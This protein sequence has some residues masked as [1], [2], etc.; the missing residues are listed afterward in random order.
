MPLSD[1]NT[2]LIPYA[3]V[4]ADGMIRRTGLSEVSMVP[5]QAVEVDET[6]IAD[7]IEPIEGVI[8]ASAEGVDD[9]THRWDFSD[10]EWAILPPRPSEPHY[11]DAGTEAWVEYPEKPNA[12]CE[13]N[14]TKWVDS[15]TEGDV[16]DALWNA[17][18]STYAEIYAVMMRAAELGY[19]GEP[20]VIIGQI[21]NNPS[22]LPNVVDEFLNALPTEQ[23]DLVLAGMRTRP[24]G[25]TEP[26]LTG[27]THPND[28]GDGII[29]LIPWLESE[30]SITI[31]PEQLD[32]LFGVILP[33]P[34]HE[35]E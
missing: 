27:P 16:E 32:D 19:L 13:W 11:W 12:F 34:F 3:V 33:P 28:P 21:A 15:R 5:L 29:S 25:R 17:R 1:G 20:I 2:A 26:R 35:A 31:T 18:L 30:H 14:G 23:H 9:D 4:D 6:V 8:D 10:G 24:I 7:T 22:G